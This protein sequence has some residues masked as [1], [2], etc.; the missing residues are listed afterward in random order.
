[1]PIRRT[2]ME[3]K[4]QI[5]S[6]NMRFYE[7]DGWTLELLNQYL[8]RGKFAY[9]DHKMG[10]SCKGEMGYWILEPGSAIDARKLIEDGHVG[11]LVGKERWAELKHMGTLEVLNDRNWT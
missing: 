10:F 9:M 11:E 7:V 1:M 4:I 3:K 6:L 5:S 2:A 8:V